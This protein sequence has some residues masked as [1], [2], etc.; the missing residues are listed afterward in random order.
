VSSDGS[1]TRWIREAKA[2]DATAVQR[3]WEWYFHQLVKLCR[4]KLR[5]CPRR[6]ADEEDV[7]L[8]AFDSFCQRAANGQFPELQDRDD[9]WRLLVV[10]AARKAV[11][12]A[13]HERRKRRDAGRV[14]AENVLQGAPHELDAHGLERIISREPTPEFA[15]LVAE[16]CDRLLANLEDDRLR[17]V[18]IW[19]MEGFSNEDIAQQL[20]CSVRTV[21]RK[22]ALIRMRLSGETTAC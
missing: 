18:A 4:K 22:L 5:S 16:Q 21:E 11:N 14:I 9:L 19:K 7:A 2:G 8:S 10:I 17:Q 20:A 13:Q 6:A 15:A 12:L 1:V 3:L